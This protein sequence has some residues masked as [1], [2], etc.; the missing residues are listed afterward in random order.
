MLTAK[1]DRA[2]WTSD[3]GSS[4]GSP[5]NFRRRGGRK[6]TARTG[7]SQGMS[8]A[9]RKIFFVCVTVL[10]TSYYKNFFLH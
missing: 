1:K 3:R 2:A 9:S 5:E 6:F 8:R 4:C 7:G 10:R